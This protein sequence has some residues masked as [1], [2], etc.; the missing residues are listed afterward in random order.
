MLETVQDEHRT[1]IVARYRRDVELARRRAEE[2][3]AL[4]GRAHRQYSRLLAAAA[5]PDGNT[6]LTA[7]APFRQLA[8]DGLRGV[9][10]VSDAAGPPGAAPAPDAGGQ[11]DAPEVV[12]PTG[13]RPLGW[14]DPRRAG[15]YE[16]DEQGRWIVSF[17]DDEDTDGPVPVHGLPDVAA[18]LVALAWRSGAIHAACGE[19]EGRCEHALGVARAKVGLS[20]ERR[21]AIVNATLVPLEEAVRHGA[22]VGYALAVC[23]N[24]VGGHRAG[25][26]EW[27]EHAYEELEATGCSPDA[28]LTSV[29]ADFQR[30]SAALRGAQGSP[31][32]LTEKG[33][34]R[35]GA[36]PASTPA[37][38][39][40][41]TY[42][43]TPAGE[44]YLQGYRDAVP[45]RLGHQ[46]GQA[47]PSDASEGLVYLSDRRRR[48]R[49]LR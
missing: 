41:P 18:G 28:H 10:Y 34:A 39:P 20:F 33:P 35:P 40:P 3:L 36:G 22:R 47:G 26:W 23:A 9:R 14:A 15:D 31:G 4:Y 46:G 17:G 27:M 8:N 11:L 6:S 44:A 19:W 38:G 21:R 43:T 13:A 32:R 7:P 16:R 37:E 25:W 42:R 12:G 49:L 1:E 45:G 2:E 29:L 24:G 30:R 48:P 5:L